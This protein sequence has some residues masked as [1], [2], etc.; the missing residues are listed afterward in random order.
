MPKITASDETNESIHVKQR[1][2]YSDGR[3]GILISATLQTSI[4]ASNP[5]G[6]FINSNRK[7]SSIPISRKVQFYSARLA[8]QDLGN[9][10]LLITTPPLWAI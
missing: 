3:F 10:L 2:G 6:S 1:V 5:S 8:D 9:S 7:R 4:Y